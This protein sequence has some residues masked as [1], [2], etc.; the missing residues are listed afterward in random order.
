MRQTGP[1]IL[2]QQRNSTAPAN[3]RNEL[4]YSFRRIFC[5]GFA[6]CLQHFHFIHRTTVPRRF[7]A[8]QLPEDGG[9]TPSRNFRALPGLP[10]PRTVRADL[11]NR[12]HEVPQEASESEEIPA[13]QRSDGK[14]AETRKRPRQ[15]RGP[16]GPQ[17][18][19]TPK[20]I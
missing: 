1:T 10:V 2:L 9:A 16:G 5:G 13:G 3:D 18:S 12:A 11:R 17:S 4:A 15:S 20:Q 19:W 14:Q 8:I 7:S 6:T